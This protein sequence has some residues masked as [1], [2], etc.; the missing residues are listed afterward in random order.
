MYGCNITNDGSS[1]FS[2]GKKQ[3][4][5]LTV[6]LQNYNNKRH[7][8]LTMYTRG[9]MCRYK[10]IILNLRQ[11][12]HRIT[13]NTTSVYLWGSKSLFIFLCSSC[14]VLTC[15]VC[16]RK[17]ERKK[18]RKKRGTCQKSK[19]L[20]INLTSALRNKQLYTR[21]FSKQKHPKH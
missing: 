20:H 7:K 14:A 11:A 9:R 13:V 17:K 19:Y 4:L 12:S 5:E 10:N 3:N 21:M 16:E 18:R 1:K 2:N 6:T 8:C 15:G